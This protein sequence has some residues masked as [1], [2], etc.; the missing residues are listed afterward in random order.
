MTVTIQVFVE[1]IRGKGAFVGLAAVDIDLDG[2]ELRLRGVRVMRRANGRLEVSLP[3][4]RDTVGTWAP[5]VGLPPELF[6]V[7]RAKV[8]GMMACH[9]D[10]PFPESSSLWATGA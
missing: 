6:E 8:L 2:I 3:V 5:A 7:I 1:R 4:Y 10:S 9:L